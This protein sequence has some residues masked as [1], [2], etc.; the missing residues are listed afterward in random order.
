MPNLYG[1][2][3][4]RIPPPTD[5]EVED[6]GEDDVPRTRFSIDGSGVVE[7][8]NIVVENELASEAVQGLALSIDAVKAAVENLPAQMPVAE[9]IDLSPVTDALDRLAAAHAALADSIRASEAE[10]EGIVTQTIERDRMGNVTA[11]VTKKG[12]KARRRIVERGRDGYIIGT[13][14]K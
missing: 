13:V 12:G 14:E 4:R 8:R 5:M 3:P 7:V 2:S 9:P 6:E 10:D 1:F 11:V